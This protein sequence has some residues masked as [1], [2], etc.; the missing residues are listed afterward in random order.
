M[1]NRIGT[2]NNAYTC[3]NVMIQAYGKS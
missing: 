2:K 1:K 3:N